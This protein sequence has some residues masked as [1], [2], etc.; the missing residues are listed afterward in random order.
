[1]GTVFSLT[2][3]DV[4]DGASAALD[5]VMAWLEHVEATF[6]TFRQ[7]SEISR[8]GRGQLALA[9]CSM[10]VREVLA[11]CNREEDMSDGAFSAW[12][13]GR[14]DPAG[15]VKG[16]GIAGAGARLAAHGLANYCVNGGGDVQ[17]AG[18]GRG[19]GWIIGVA[20]PFVAGAL[21]VKVRVPGAI[22]TSGSYERGSHIAHA[23]TGRRGPLASL[24]VLAPTILWAD[25]HATAGFAM[26]DARPWLESLPGV[27]ALG[28]LTD[29]S[30]WTTAGFAGHCVGGAA[31]PLAAEIPRL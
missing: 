13:G 3:L 7:D 1:M 16:W 23:R 6:S 11:L 17:C 27:E 9:E 10:E 24:T 26:S 22:A 5:D 8:L 14:L 2:V 21:L 18:P 28:V 15:M 19:A 31:D 29:G 12:R 25:A 30:Y 4:A 20:H